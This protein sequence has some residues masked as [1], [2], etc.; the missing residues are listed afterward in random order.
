MRIG[1]EASSDRENGVVSKCRVWMMRWTAVGVV[2]MR[3]DRWEAG[4]R[5][6]L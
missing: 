3:R 6:A 2:L 5:E 4:D 1:K